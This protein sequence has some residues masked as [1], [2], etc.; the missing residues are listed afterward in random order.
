MTWNPLEY[1]IKHAIMDGAYQGKEVS[2]DDDGF[3]QKIKVNNDGTADV[4]WFAPSNSE[5]KHWHFVF[6]LDSNGNA[7]PGSGKLCHN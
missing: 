1:D 5:K 2:F 4:D 3:V 6:K 7:I